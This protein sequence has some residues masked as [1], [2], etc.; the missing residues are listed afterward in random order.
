MIR[1]YGASDDLVEVEGPS[2]HNEFGAFDKEIALLIG[3]GSGGLVVRFYYAPLRQ[4]KNDV[5][6]GATWQA[7]IDVVDEDTP[8]PWP[9]S[10]K[11]DGY[12]VVVEVDAPAST[13]WRRLDDEEE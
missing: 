6:D 1:I 5:G 2:G 8:I 12:T 9:V 7:R 11:S 4:P 10:I 13:K 3:D